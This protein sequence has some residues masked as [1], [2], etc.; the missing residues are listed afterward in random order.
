MTPKDLPERPRLTEDELKRATKARP[1]PSA[2]RACSGSMTRSAGGNGQTRASPGY[3]QAMV[4]R[5][6]PVRAWHHSR[7]VS[8]R[9]WISQ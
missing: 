9:F 5:K 1:P 8:L 4:S 6:P 7:G 3:S 2:I